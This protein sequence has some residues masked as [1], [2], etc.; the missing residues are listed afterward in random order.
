MKKEEPNFESVRV[1]QIGRNL[2]RVNQNEEKSVGKIFKKKRISEV[3]SYNKNDANIFLEELQNNT[4]LFTRRFYKTIHERPDKPIP[5]VNDSFFERVKAA[6]ENGKKH[7]HRNL[8]QASGVNFRGKSQGENLL[9]MGMYERSYYYMNHHMYQ[10]HDEPY[11]SL[12]FW[13]REFTEPFE[14][15]EEEVEGGEGEEI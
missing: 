10:L 13:V 3:T 15:T 2:I 7:A 1:S 11:L 12:P 14:D 5:F 4:E 8:N 6:A 9:G